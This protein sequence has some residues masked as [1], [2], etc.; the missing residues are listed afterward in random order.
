MNNSHKKHADLKRPSFGNF[1]R[2]EWA[3]LGAPCVTIKLLSAQIINALSPAFKC[4]YVDTV[5]NDEVTVLP[6]R[7][8]NGAV[9][10]YS[11]EIG[12]ARLNYK[13]PF[14]SFK[15]RETFSQPDMVIANGNHHPAKTQVVI[16]IGNKR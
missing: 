1:G 9:L 5:H 7:L 14:N 10:E 15:L 4:A 16:I 2:N 11:D 12:Y 13:P 6:G 3:I 8:E